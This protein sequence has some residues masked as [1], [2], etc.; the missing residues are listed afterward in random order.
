MLMALQAS[1]EPSLPWWV[2][3]GV[4]L[5]LVWATWRLARLS[6][7]AGCI[8]AAVGWL[9]IF[10]AALLALPSDRVGVILL[11]TLAPVAA[12]IAALVSRRGG[13]TAGGA[14]AATVPVSHL[15][16]AALQGQPSARS[17]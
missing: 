11:V 7:W 1:T 15:P 13:G 14:A 9:F 6:W 5:L 8:T 17:V 10:T 16:P 4:L 2:L 3:Y 12:W